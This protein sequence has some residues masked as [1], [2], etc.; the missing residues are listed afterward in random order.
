M[1]KTAIQKR[2]K[3]KVSKP[4][5]NLWQNSAY[6]IS[7]AWIRNKSVIWLCLILAVLAVA[8][9]VLGLLIAP[10]ILGAVENTAPLGQLVAII[11]L[12]AAGLM[13]VNTAN[14]YVS[15]NAGFGRIAVRVLII[16]LINDKISK[17]SYPN[18]ENQDIR[19]KLDKAN[20][21]ASDNGQATEAIWS[22]LTNLLQNIAGF[23]I[24]LILLSSLD[25]WIIA[26]VLATT[27]T[28]F[29]IDKYINGWGYRHR[30]E[31]AEYSRRMNYISEKAGDYTLAKDIRI[32]GMRGWLTDMYDKTLRL[33][34][35]FT[36]RGEKVYIRANV[37]DIILSFVRNGVAYIYLIGLILSDGLSA[38]QFLLYFS[39]VGG[40]TAWVSGIFSGFATLHTQ[41]LD[42]S[43]V[44]EFLEYPEPFKFEDGEPIEPDMKKPY[45]IE[46]K[47]V[48]FRYPGA[49]TDTLKTIN[50]VIKAG[51]K[52]AVVGLNGAGKT[53]LVKLVC[54]FY[55]PTEG[56]ILMNGEN[57]KKYNRRDYYRHFSA[58]FQQ[59]SL[60]ATTIAENIMQT[61]NPDEIDIEKMRHCAEKSG[62]AKKI[63]NLPQ[64]YETHFRKEVYEDGTEFSGGETQRLML[65]RALY[66]NA[67]VI[68]LDE[69]TAALDPI[70]ESDMYNKYN[71]FADG[72][73]SVYISHRLAS[74]RF[75]D[76]I[77]FIDDGLITEEG[78]H[79]TLIK[80]NG[81]YAELFEIQS[82]YY[83]EGVFEHEE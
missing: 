37:V 4:K 29:F 27:I 31:E 73:T 65:A 51:E 56:E 11:L 6:M 77:I 13:L 40:F 26:L 57:I 42:L 41:S 79:D 54:G 72:R 52:L 48:S 36:A 16:S 71:D 67:P 3:E 21:A 33:Y 61:D 60:F 49:D 12:F 74:T 46:L 59:F 44:R 35:A 43:A 55:D 83:R 68:I 23:I 69:P 38:P 9:N 22:T 70:A 5:Y 25:L 20:M 10:T 15:T 14:S 50:L 53:T 28:G 80:Q 75:C 66:K 76:R 63:E 39:A 45:Q 78:T 81:K 32:F 34:Q 30:D 24:Y 7:L 8:S 18:T 58:V 2:K 17:T 47:N 82:H 62:L 19:K 1:D 64:K